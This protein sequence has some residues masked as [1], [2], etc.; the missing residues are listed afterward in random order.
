MSGLYIHIPF[1][2]EK[3]S[4]CDFFSGNQLYL[5]E[6][7]VDALVRELTIRKDYLS[8]S[9][10]NT[11]Y[12]GGGTPSLL[13]FDQLAKLMG[14]IKSN[15]DL[16]PNTEI[17]IECNPENI[18]REFVTCLADLEI[19]RISLGIQFMRDDVLL[20]Y[21]RHHSKELII[22]ALETIVQNY[23]ENLSVDLI[24]DVPEINDREL[25][26]T[27]NILADFD[28]KHYSAYSLTIAKN[29][30][31]FWQRRKSKYIENQ[32]DSSLL[33][34]QLIHDFLEDR[35]FGQYEVSNY[36]KEGFLSRHNLGYWN[37]SPYLGIGVSAHSYNLNS[38][39]WNHTNIKRYL[40]EMEDGQIHPEIEYMDDIQRYNEYVIL[41]LR[42]FL[43]LSSEDIFKNFG[44]VLGQ[45][46]KQG[47]EKL[48]KDGHFNKEKGMYI[49]LPADLLLADHFAKILM[50]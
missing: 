30:R 38:R 47:I 18:H 44:N 26:E 19:N 1:C 27:L 36:C 14:G 7:Y 39:Q 32:E 5:V 21:N 9:T 35:G 4:Y 29:T 42:T 34:Y 49:P 12:L 28:I 24:Y 48:E 3:C 25:L 23:F 45:H 2:T 16:G 22:S 10:I 41:R 31:L 43:G 8:G 40:R 15:Y 33:Q 50:F 37:Q 20:K 13:S 6:D 17:T 46:F 11:I